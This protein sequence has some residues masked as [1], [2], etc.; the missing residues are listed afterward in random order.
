MSLPSVSCA[1]VSSVA[2]LPGAL[3]VREADGEYRVATADEVLSQARSLLAERVKPGALLSSPL[4]VKDYLRLEIGSLEHEVFCVVF[5]DS[6][7]CVIELVQ[8]FRGTITQTA[9]Y[10]REIVKE[11]LKRNA[12]AVVLAHN[13]PSSKADPSAADLHL[14]KVVQQALQLIDVHVLDHLVVTAKETVSFAE[15]GLM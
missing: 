15:T 10:P 13:H 14:T 4:A 6:Q 1:V 8:M 5:L 11:A 3:L 9:V 12:G 7:N 2:E